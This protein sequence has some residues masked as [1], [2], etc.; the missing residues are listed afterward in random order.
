MM[1]CLTDKM[2]EALLSADLASG[3]LGEVPLGTMYGLEARGLISPTW[4]GG[5]GAPRVVRAFP[6][7]A[8]QSTTG[9]RFPHYFGDDLT[10]AGIRTA[11]ELQGKPIPEEE[12]APIIAEAPG[13]EIPLGGAWIRQRG[14]A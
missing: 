13:D 9:G 6:A 5:K 4:R 8:G 11:W 12:I 10:K 14:R 7:K 1:K 3:T 2:R